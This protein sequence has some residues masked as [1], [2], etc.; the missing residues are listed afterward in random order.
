VDIALLV[1]SLL[2]VVFGGIAILPSLGLDIRIFGRSEMASEV[3][4]ENKRQRKPWLAFA[5]LAV[6]IGLSAGAF[7]YFFRPRIVEKSVERI[8]VKEKTIQAVC[9]KVTSPKQAATTRSAPTSTSS[10]APA[11]SPLSPPA[12]AVAP[13]TLDCGGGSCAQSFGQTG[14]VTAGTVRVD[15]PP[16]SLTTTLSE[17][18]KPASLSPALARFNHFNILTVT[19]NVQ[20]QPVAF[21]F[22]CDQELKQVQVDMISFDNDTALINPGNLKAGYVYRAE[23]VGA[24]M[25]I[26]V[27]IFSDAA[28]T[29][30]ETVPIVVTYK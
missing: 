12:S 27:H 13:A 10:T 17:V 3:R 15:T 16:L 1:I 28:L 19:P 25:P 11:T 23:P 4:I 8:V 21:R 24:G 20:W 2:G 30:C 6:S 7:Y 22:T 9:P 5:V 14:G 26:P 18:E 29:K